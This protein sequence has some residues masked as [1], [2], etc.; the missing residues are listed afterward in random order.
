MSD[1]GGFEE[2][3]ARLVGLAYRMLGSVTD[4]ED[5]VQDAWL[6]WRE[7][8]RGAVR[9]E[10]A[11]L[12]T[13]VTRLCLDRLRRAR[14]RRVDYVGPWLPEPALS[15]AEGDRTDADGIGSE[16][17]FALMLALERL[18][19]LERAAFL[20]HDVFGMDFDEVGRALERTAETCRKLASRA[21]VH[22]RDE[23]PRFRVSPEEGARVAE[24]FRVAVRDG[25]LDGLRAML[26]DSATLVSD[27]GGRKHAALLPIVGADKIA[28]L[29][30]GLSKKGILVEPR[31]H[32][33]MRINGLPGW[34]SREADGTLQTVA[35]AVEEGRIATIYVTRNPDKLAHLERLERDGA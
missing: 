28:R 19:P 14:G 6:R 18:S 2:H 25:D 33:P 31:W 21:R 20:L 15:A 1:A 24:A 23:R 12:N 29:Y 3:R 13:V 35:L 17:S 9:S 5:A 34:A 32:R 4:A 27:G 30:V 10:P 11:F 26:A 16:A 22:V 8:D 7:A